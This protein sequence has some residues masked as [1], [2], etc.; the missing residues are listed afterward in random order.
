MASPP[1]A[2]ASVAGRL[3]HSFGRDLLYRYRV[4]PDRGFD[5]VS[6]SCHALTGYTPAEF[7]ADPRLM[8]GLVHPADAALV[9]PIT[10]RPLAAE[11]LVRWVRR[12][13]AIIWTSHQARV[14]PDAEGRPVAFEGLVR[15]ETEAVLAREALAALGQS[16][17]AFLARVAAPA[18]VLDA[19]GRVLYA[20]ARLLDLSRRAPKEVVGKPWAAVLEH[21]DDTAAGRSLAAT[22]SGGWTAGRE[23]TTPIVLRDGRTHLVR[24]V[25]LPLPSAGGQPVS[26]AFMGEDL[27]ADQERQAH[28]AELTAAVEHTA[29][30]VLLTD[31]QARI[32][33]VNPA[34]EAATGYRAGDVIGQN[35]RL[36]KSGHHDAEFYA[37]LWWTIAHGEA[38]HGEMVNKRADGGLLVAEASIVPVRDGRGIPVGYVSVQHD[39][40]TM[41]D[42]RTSI[43]DTRRQR[44]RLGGALAGITLRESVD[45]TCRDIAKVLADLPGVI[46]AGVGL[47]EDA[48]RVRL[49]GIAS[50]SMER[51]AQWLEPMPQAAERICRTDA[52]PWVDPVAGMT[53]PVRAGALRA[54]GM[55]AVLFVPVRQEG[56]PLGVLIVGGAD[57]TGADL[58][59]QKPALG[60]VAAVLRAV[61]GPQSSPHQERQLLR[62]RTRDLIADGASRPVYQ[63]IRDM[64][65]G[66]ISGLEALT[67]FTDGTAPDRAFAD[68]ERCGMGEELELAT[69]RAAIRDSLALR[70]GAWL[71]LNV[72]AALLLRGGEIAT[73]LRS[74]HREIVVEITQ[75]SAGTDYASARRALEAIGSTIRIAVDDAGSGAADYRHLVE[76]RPDFV[77][78]GVG[79][80]RGIERDLTR[81]A[82]VA[83]LR[84]FSQAS[85]G[86]L[87]GEGIETAEE[88]AMLVRLGV[89]FGQGYHLGRP[90]PADAW[91]AQK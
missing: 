22:P 16:T 64:V 27:T 58:R 30:A 61:L 21:P 47:V 14:A 5:Y 20:N 65:T 54:A 59:A 50:R 49:A 10:G 74:A 55:E 75:G 15:D 91:S 80:V 46:A 26:T 39:V 36:L 88:Q 38:W 69:L 68:A 62:E 86:A 73:L 3:S 77:K 29:D 1:S 37:N 66:R 28:V 24:W 83:G 33:Y 8:A 32:H 17:C 52:P 45:E 7:L 89:P 51:S 13:G 82:V 34:F 56:Q 42:L 12:D 57:R 76:L 41:R 18:V 19:L 11:R 81:Q 43:D 31:L 63:P 72:S 4:A 44:E 35:P 71:S 67:R 70:K 25:A 6:P 48:G 40:A 23:V 9:D 78:L 84:Q 90:E 53:D 87:I 85:G 2:D 60:E 79:L